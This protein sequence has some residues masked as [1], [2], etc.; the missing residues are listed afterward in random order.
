MKRVYLDAS[1]II[2]LVEASAPFHDAAVKCVLKHRAG[3]DDVVL[4]SRISWLECR[5]KPLRT[6]DDQLL[7]SY[8]KFLTAGELE[9]IEITPAI[10]QRATEIRARYRLATPDAI[11]MATALERHADVVITGDRDLGRCP[12]IEVDRITLPE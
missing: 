1:C 11:Q 2:Y 10:V 7:A 3:T 9:T 8:D 6:D 4:T 5:V 12:G